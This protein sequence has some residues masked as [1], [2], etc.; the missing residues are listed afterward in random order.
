M[1]NMATR[2]R[3]AAEAGGLR[4]LPLAAAAALVFAPAAEGWQT[5]AEVGLGESFTDN[6]NLRGGS[7]RQSDWVTEVAPGLRVSGR[8]ARASGDLNMHLRGLAHTAEGK[9]FETRLGLNGSGKFELIDD[10]VFLDSSASVSQE[11][12]SQFGATNTGSYQDVNATE[13]RQLNLSPYV[14]WRIGNE[15]L[16]VLRYRADFSDSS[17]QIV[18]ERLEQRLSLDLQN[19][20][21]WGRLGW[22]A[23]AETV[24]AEAGNA[25]STESDMANVSLLY[26]LTPTLR[27]EAMVGRE[28]NN[29]RT[30]DKESYDNY[31]GGFVWTPQ[32]RTSLSVR[33]NKRYFGWARDYRLRHAMQRVAFEAGY[34]RDVQA[35]SLDRNGVVTALDMFEALYASRQ[36]DPVLRRAQ[37]LNLLQQAGLSPDE[38][39]PSGILTNQQT[40]SRRLFVSMVASGIRNTFMLSVERAERSAVVNQNVSLSIFVSDFANY[41]KTIED[42]VSFAWSNRLSARTTANLGLDYSRARGTRVMTTE[43]DYR[44]TTGL[45]VGLS[46]TLGAHTRGG[47][48]YR[49]TRSTGTTAYHENAVTASLTYAF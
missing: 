46:T 19:G 47:L 17:N 39:F 26:G 13:V 7:A 34:V 16:A 42:R 8:S 45:D 31:G 30:I 43:E 23:H 27:L 21:Q 9:D 37:I 35:S 10:R 33:V 14:R 11:R 41:S 5:T 28:R 36:P 38:L 18:D 15:G 49:Y 6:A 22:S 40:E 20:S 24:Q 32:P 2:K 25:R 3:S 12:V 4:L 44:R 1:V 48:K 29:F